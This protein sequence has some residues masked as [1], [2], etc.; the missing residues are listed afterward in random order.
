MIAIQA[1]LQV[2][3]CEIHIFSRFAVVRCKRYYDDACPGA[4]RIFCFNT[5]M[6]KLALLW[7]KAC[8]CKDPLLTFFNRSQSIGLILNDSLE[9]RDVT[10]Q[11][12][13]LAFVE[14]RSTL[15]I[16]YDH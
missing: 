5:V 9:I 13:D 1:K 6:C 11:V 12:F 2:V 15:G 4:A 16:L 14:L 8:V 10:S 3:Q 7:A